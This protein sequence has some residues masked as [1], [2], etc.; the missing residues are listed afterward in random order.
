M[1]SAVMEVSAHCVLALG[2]SALVTG[3]ENG[4]HF[5]GCVSIWRGVLAVVVSSSAALLILEVGQPGSQSEAANFSV[6]ACGLKGRLQQRTMAHIASAYDCLEQYR[7]Q[8]H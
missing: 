1:R 5:G 6:P 2:Q 4:S 7:S 8:C 3:Q